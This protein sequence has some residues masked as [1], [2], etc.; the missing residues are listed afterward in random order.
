[1][2]FDNTLLNGIKAQMAWN[3]AKRE[4]VGFGTAGVCPHCNTPNA[5]LLAG[6]YNAHAGTGKAQFRCRT[7]AR[8]WTWARKPKV[9]K[10]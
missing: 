5:H 8:T 6:W 3:R 1:M 7:C 9:V 2:Q 10:R 4:D